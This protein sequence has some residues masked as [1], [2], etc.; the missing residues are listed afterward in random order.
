MNENTLRLKFD[1]IDTKEEAQIFI[2][3]KILLPES[4]INI[5]ESPQKKDDF[6]GF[7]LVEKDKGEIGKVA[8]LLNFSGNLVF[9]V[10][11]QGKEMLIPYNKDFI[12]KIDYQTKTIFFTAPQGLFEIF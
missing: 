12:N 5:S 2:G 4:E 8:E 6:E 10:F 3:C 1:D 9:Q 11:S 7:L